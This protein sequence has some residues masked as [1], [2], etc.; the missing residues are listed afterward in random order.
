MSMRAER[1]EL[2]GSE[3]RGDGAH[4]RRRGEGKIDRRHAPLA[5][6]A[7]E[8]RAGGSEVD[9]QRLL[10]EDRLAVIEGEVGIGEVGRGRCGD[11]DAIDGAVAGEIGRV[12]GEEAH[13]QAQQERR[14]EP[15][16]CLPVSGAGRSRETAMT[17]G[18]ARAL[19]PRSGGSLDRE[20]VRP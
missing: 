16:R 7:R 2:A 5:L 17:P 9:R 19:A 1:A 20:R 4:R 12:I 14:E 10:A 3:R 13:H 18:W 6:D 15:V 8:A 11:I